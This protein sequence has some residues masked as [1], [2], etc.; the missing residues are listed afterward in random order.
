M[1]RWDLF[2]RGVLVR[3]WGQSAPTAA[4]S[5]EFAGEFEA[6]Q[7][8]RAWHRRSGKGSRGGSDRTR[9]GLR[10]GNA[11]ATFSRNPEVLATHFLERILPCCRS[12]GQL[13]EEGS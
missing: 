11:S 7:T 3:N 12:R 5:E 10:T 2:G 4:S 6:G 13:E 1:I 9:Q 8:L